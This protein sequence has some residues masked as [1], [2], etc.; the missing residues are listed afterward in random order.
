ME[1]KNFRFCKKCTVMETRLEYYK[2]VKFALVALLVLPSRKAGLLRRRTGTH[3]TKRSLV[4]VMTH[5]WHYKSGLSRSRPP[6]RPFLVRNGILRAEGV[7]LIKNVCQG[8]SGGDIF[9]AIKSAPVRCVS[10]S[11]LHPFLQFN[12]MHPTI[13]G[14]RRILGFTHPDVRVNRILRYP[15][16]TLLID[17]MLSVVPKDFSQCLIAMV[18]DPSWDMLKHLIIASVCSLEPRD[19]TCYFELALINARIEQFPRANAVGCLFHWK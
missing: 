5:R 17:E 6:R 1:H 14:T 16:L 10:E 12:M 3:M 11:D 2:C 18:Y 8:A 4:S 13:T 7:I 19:V 15:Q 9:R